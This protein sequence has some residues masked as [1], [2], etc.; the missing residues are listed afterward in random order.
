MDT[1]LLHIFRLQVEHQ[2]YAAVLAEQEART[3]LRG[4]Y[5]DIGRFFA[6]I[7]SCLTAVANIS[8]ALW[9]QSGRYAKER[10][11]LRITLGVSDD[12]PLKSTSM[13]NN[14]EHIDERIDW[15][16]EH[17]VH[18]NYSDHI[19]SSGNDFVGLGDTTDVFRHFDYHTG[20]VTFWGMRYPLN[21]I[22]AEVKRL[23]SVAQ[24]QARG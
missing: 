6:N 22:L 21:P 20:E 14:F 24:E 4:E 2:C 1:T 12:S 3:A 9:G 11:E 19:I 8:K 23:H 18:K 16:Y 17:S 5:M 10:E 15:W 13:R 7:Q